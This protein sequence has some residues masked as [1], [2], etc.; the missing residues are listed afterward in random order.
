MLHT[1]PAGLS[2]SREPL[3]FGAEI[4]GFAHDFDSGLYVGQHDDGAG[5]QRFGQDFS[6]ASFDVGQNFIAALAFAEAPANAFEICLQVFVGIIVYGE[7][8]SAQIDIQNLVHNLMLYLDSFVF[9]EKMLS[10]YCVHERKDRVELV[11]G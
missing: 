4:F 8:I 3:P 11:D 2:A 6:E 1:Q 10:G 9:P 5:A 7:G